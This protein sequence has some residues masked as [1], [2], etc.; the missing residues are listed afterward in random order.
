MYTTGV[1]YFSIWRLVET[2]ARPERENSLDDWTD[3][4]FRHSNTDPNAGQ[5]ECGLTP[6][7]SPAL[8][9]IVIGLLFSC[10]YGMVRVQSRDLTIFHPHSRLTVALFVL[11]PVAF[12]L[13]C[14]FAALRAEQHFQP[15]ADQE[16]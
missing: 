11:V 5:D 14:I 12:L 3:C 4:V 15:A 8:V 1:L 9:G 13:I 10:G 6:E 2:V 7:H 16:K